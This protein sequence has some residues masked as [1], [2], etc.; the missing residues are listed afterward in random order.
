MLVTATLSLLAV[1]LGSALIGLQQARDLADVEGRLVPR[2]EFGPRIESEF[3]HLR[4][5]M[6]DAVAAQDPA[7]L[8]EAGAARLRLFELITNTSA[9]L[10]EAAETR[11]RWAIQDYYVQA[12]QVSRRLIAGDTGEE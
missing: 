6:Q 3:D 2:L 5:A 10:D 7:G 9:A 8:D 12:E 1:V 4:Q 11:L